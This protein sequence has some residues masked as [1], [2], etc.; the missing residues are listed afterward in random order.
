MIQLNISNFEFENP[1]NITELATICEAF[2]SEIRLNIVKQLREKSYSIA[3]LRKMNNISYSSILFH[4]NILNK[5]GIV[6]IN[7]MP[8]NKG[9]VQIISLKYRH[10]F[11][12]NQTVKNKNEVFYQSI[13]VGCFTKHHVYG[14]C[15]MA[16]TDFSLMGMNT[17][18]LDSQR[19]NASLIWAE[20]GFLE[21]QFSKNKF[22]NKTVKELKFSLEICSEAQYYREDWKSDITFSINGIEVC[23]WQS[24]GDFGERRGTLNPVEWP[25]CNTQYGILLTIC[26]NENGTY[27]NEKKYSNNITI[28]D[29]KIKNNTGITF[30]IHSKEDAIHHGGFNIFGKNFGD[31][32]Q[33]IE[34]ITICE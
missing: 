9:H 21:Y 12:E 4:I 30:K 1:E 3:E 23:M 19:F 13:G 34:L 32:S 7:Y 5:A 16:G 6:D 33:D 20:S 14:H 22:K 27:I 24:P 11:I 17:D 28:N 29:L 18:L 10:F 26:V 31:Y 2:A 15:G 25:S 8:S